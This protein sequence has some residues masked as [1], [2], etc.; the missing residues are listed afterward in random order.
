MLS[1]IHAGSRSLRLLIL[2]VFALVFAAGCGTA[3]PTATLTATPPI[4]PTVDESAA[5]PTIEAAT[6]EEALT[7]EAP[8]EASA[9]EEALT[10]EAAAQPDT[11]VDA[12]A[13]VSDRPA[14]QTLTLTDVRTGQTFSLADFTGK[15]VYVEPMATW[16]TNCRRQLSNVVTA[17]NQL[18]PEQYVFVAVS[19]ETNISNEDL[20][21][22]TDSTG[23]DW[24]F[25]V[26]TPEMLTELVNAFGRT[27]AN[28]P[29]TPHFIIRPDG[30]YTELLTGFEAPEQI[31]ERLQAIS[32]L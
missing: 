5:T 3:T 12:A 6:T 1:L 7:E 28:P 20:K 16:C 27:I 23:F 25:A 30:S 8:T 2:P 15:T 9:T 10:E 4:V 19:V 21:N 18:D 17:R 26:L 11:V 31:V 13:G 32:G 24:T 29:S 22:Y 14:W